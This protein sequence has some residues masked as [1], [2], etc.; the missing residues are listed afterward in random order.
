MAGTPYVS[1]AGTAILLRLAQVENENQLP[2]VWSGMAKA[3][4]KVKQLVELNNALA[5]ESISR[6]MNTNVHVTPSIKEKLLRLE[7]AMVN[8]GDWLSGLGPF[9]FG[10]GTPEEVQRRLGVV[11]MYEFMNS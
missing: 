1:I 7:Y 3:K 10:T 9:V 5:T 6:G 4:G 2:S 8:R 11:A